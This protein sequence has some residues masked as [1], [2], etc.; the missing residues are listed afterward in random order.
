MFFHA[1]DILF[2]Y[3]EH[4]RDEVHRAELNDIGTGVDISLSIPYDGRDPDDL[5]GAN[6][7]VQGSD[8]ELDHPCR[9]ILRTPKSMGAEETKA[10]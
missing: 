2:A 4:Q 10:G 3:R 5:L 8:M 7:W 1:D 9:R 6:E